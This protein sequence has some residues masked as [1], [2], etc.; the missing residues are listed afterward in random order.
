MARRAVPLESLNVQMAG[1]GRTSGPWMTTELLMID[2]GA[3]LF[4]RASVI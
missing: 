3:Q 2:Q 1:C 4:F